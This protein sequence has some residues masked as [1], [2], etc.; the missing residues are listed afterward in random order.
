MNICVVG[1]QL[2]EYE[3]HVESIFG[4][5]RHE[6]LQ[7]IIH[8]GVMHADTQMLYEGKLNLFIPDADLAKE[9]DGL[10]L[11]AKSPFVSELRKL[12]LF[13]FKQKCNA[14][15]AEKSDA[16]DAIMV[17]IASINKL[18]YLFTKLELEKFKK[19][20]K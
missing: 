12:V 19:E 15:I 9:Y 5:S 16:E 4:Y 1:Y 17:H 8:K 20:I 10:V 3:P 11:N 7:Y 2:N 18:I 6:A 14:K 13:K